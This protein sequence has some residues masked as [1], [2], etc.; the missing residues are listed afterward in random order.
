MTDRV[1]SSGVFRRG[2]SNPILKYNAKIKIGFMVDHSLFM[3]FILVTQYM[4]NLEVIPFISNPTFA[5]S[6]LLRIPH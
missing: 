5:L 1:L 4:H 2:I 3:F 6:L